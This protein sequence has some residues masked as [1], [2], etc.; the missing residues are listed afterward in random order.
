MLSILFRS[1]SNF[2]LRCSA[3]TVDAIEKR[4]CVSSK[5]SSYPSV[6][7]SES[8]IWLSYVSSSDSSSLWY[9][10]SVF[11]TVPVAFSSI[12]THFE[13]VSFLSHFCVTGLS[14]YLSVPL[15]SIVTPWAVW[16]LLHVSS[17]HCSSCSSLACDA[18]PKIETFATA[19]SSPSFSSLPIDLFFAQSS[20]NVA[21]D[22]IGPLVLFFDD[23]SWF[24]LM[25][26]FSILVFK[27]DLILE[28][29]FVLLVSSP[30][31]MS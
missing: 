5:S 4:S 10:S 24:E 8:S 18:N 21:R 13:V 31:S 25:E 19:T 12:P 27:Y 16:A 3:S 26:S 22:S 2:S 17:I 6:Y 14:I 11:F 20:K 30:S 29:S 9:S 23:S 7:M 1:A 28:S 15:D